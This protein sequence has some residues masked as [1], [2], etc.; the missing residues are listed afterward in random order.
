MQLAPI[1]RAVRVHPYRSAVLTASLAIG[2]PVL[3]FASVV[4]FSS[5]VARR[6][7]VDVLAA[8][9]DAEVE[10]ADL[11]IHVLPKFRAE[12]HGL[13]I[14]HKGR[15][16]VPPLI[17]IER[18]SASGNL[19]G[20]LRKHLARVEVAGLDIEIPPD[21]NRDDGPDGGSTTDPEGGSASQRIARTFVI[22]ELIS[23]DARLGLI[24]DTPDNHEKVWSIHRLRMNAVSV[25]RA[26]PFVATLENAVPPGNIETSGTFGPWRSEAPGQTALHGRFVFDHADLGVFKGIA[27]I[28]SARGTFAGALE[29]IDIHGET[30]T[31][32]FTVTIGGHPMPLHATY[33]AIVDGTNGNTS[34][35]EIDASF[36]QTSLVAKG[37]VVGKPGVDGRTITLDVVMERARLED[38]LQMAVSASRPP[39][40]GALKLTTK[41]E[42]PPGDRDVVRKLEL[43]GA[44]AIVDTRF[45]D[46]E[47]QTKINDLSHRTRGES[48]DQKAA[49]VSSQ[50]AGTFT[51]R[52]G[53]L[54]IPAVAFDVPGAAVRLSGSYGLVSEQIDFAGVVETNATISAMTTGF[55]SL[56]LK[57]VD[58]IFRKDGGGSAV[59]IK[60]TGT[61]NDP[62][63]GLDKARVFRRQ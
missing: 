33:H 16:D 36:L 55:K 14:R 8:R 24:P 27:G 53:R 58:L 1:W 37:A 43:D 13:S 57:P 59:P 42:L 47:V 50:F 15:R 63:F 61:R 32:D 45:T 9:L 30:D 46:P 31:P 5:E 18:F 38:V 44:F 52:N 40:I 29:H 17:T 11:Q 4:P 56:L 28:L 41:L 23:R 6:K 48:P 35:E 39:M 60:I 25:D 49:R 20:L 12:G 19:I 10:L 21:H 2:V 3:A 62:S 26:M 54:V 51:L 34:L 22:D 7:V